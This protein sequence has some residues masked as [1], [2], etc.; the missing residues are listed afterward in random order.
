MIIAVT[1]DSSTEEIFQHFGQTKEFLLA[2]KE[3]GN[4]DFKV[5]SSGEYS[6]HEL[7]PFLKSLGVEVLLAGGMGGHA[8][9]LLNQAGIRPIPGLMG[10]AEEAAKAFFEDTLDYDPNYSHEC[11][12]H[13]GRHH[14]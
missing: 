7:V 11:D 6:H 1:Y 14:H 9:E 10:S 12:C 8:V 5:V 2:K 3:N 13:E 4:I